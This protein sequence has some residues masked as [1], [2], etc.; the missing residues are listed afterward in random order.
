MAG[1]E[2]KQI[3]IKKKSELVFKNEER[4]TVLP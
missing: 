4:N 1:D 3:I 2:I